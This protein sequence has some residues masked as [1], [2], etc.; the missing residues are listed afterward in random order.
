[1]RSLFYISYPIMLIA[2]LVFVGS[3]LSSC[4]GSTGQLSTCDGLVEAFSSVGKVVCGIISSPSDLRKISESGQALEGKV[5]LTNDTLF[6]TITKY[7]PY[8]NIVFW[9]TIYGASGKIEI[10]VSKM[11]IQNP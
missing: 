9:S 3:Q 7:S 6:Y 1:M 11:A 4:A 8:K 10:D 5:P 2:L